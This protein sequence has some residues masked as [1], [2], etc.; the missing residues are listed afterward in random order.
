MDESVYLKMISDKTASL[1]SASAEIG[2]ITANAKNE[3]RKALRV[4]GEKLGE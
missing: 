3:E 2:G 4:F 1:F